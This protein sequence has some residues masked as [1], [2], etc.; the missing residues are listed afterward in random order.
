MLNVNVALPLASVRIP[1]QRKF[2]H[3]ATLSRLSANCK[4]DNEMIPE[5]LFRP[6]DI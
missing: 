3:Y 1:S 5:A 2:A 4:G 6:P